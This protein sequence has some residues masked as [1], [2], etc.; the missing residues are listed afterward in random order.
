MITLGKKP[1]ICASVACETE[2]SL[3]NLLQQAVEQQAHVAEIRLDYLTDPHRI[4]LKTLCNKIPIPILFTNRASF[5]GG[6]FSGPEE[7][8]ISLLIN[9]IEAGAAGV[10]VEF[11]T[12]KK[13]SQKVQTKAMEHGC[14]FIISH[15]DF[16]STPDMATLCSLLSEMKA[17]HADIIKL[18]TTAENA[19]DVKRLLSLYAWQDRQNENP[20][21]LPDR[22]GHLIAFCMG[23]KGR[24]SRLCAMTL[25]SGFIYAAIASGQETAPGQLSISEVKRFLGY[26]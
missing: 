24:I 10:D 4:D 25:G 11:A 21:A 16:Q 15:H 17:T 26:W 22:G 6:R 12:E 14:T 7:E 23:E 5:E 8:R 2:T 20:P 19:D 3:Y 18:V 13:L 9:A 1:L